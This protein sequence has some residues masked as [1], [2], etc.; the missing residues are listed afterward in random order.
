[1]L[2]S[3]LLAI[4]QPASGTP[5]DPATM[6]PA[7]RR[8]AAAMG[9]WM[10]CTAPR[11]AD[12]TFPNRAAADAAAEAAL[13]ACR[14]EEEGMRAAF[15]AGLSR[16]RARAIVASIRDQFREQVRQGTIRRTPAP[17]QPKAMD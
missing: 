3:L 10:A 1:M 15:A 16:R 8:V 11:V 2:L 7:Q 4:A 14:R 9:V 5:V 13:A 12:V 6:G 17:V